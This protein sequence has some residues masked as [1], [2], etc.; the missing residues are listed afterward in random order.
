MAHLPVEVSKT[1]VEEMVKKTPIR[2]LRALWRLYRVARA[3]ASP[4]KPEFVHRSVR[5]KNPKE[6]A[7]YLK[8]AQMINPQV[9]R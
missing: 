7:I 4:P 2:V 6:L 3:R 9:Y 1:L 8:V 5:I